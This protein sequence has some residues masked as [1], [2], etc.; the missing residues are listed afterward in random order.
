MKSKVYIQFAHMH[1]KAF[2]L[3]I[4]CLNIILFSLCSFF[5]YLDT[6]SDAEVFVLLNYQKHIITVYMSSLLLSLGGAFL[7]DYAYIEK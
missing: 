6:A 3:L 2:L 5:I 7:L 1:D 4:L